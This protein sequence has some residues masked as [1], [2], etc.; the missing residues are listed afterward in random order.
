MFSKEIFCS[1]LRALREG[2]GE[3]QKDLALEFNVS[4]QK[5]ST[6]ETGTRE[7]NMAAIVALADYFDVSTDYL[8]GRVDE[9]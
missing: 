8:L 3:Q 5:Y 1:R 7:P 9:P 4:K 2:R 6:W